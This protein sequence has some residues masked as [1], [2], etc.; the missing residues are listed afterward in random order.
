MDA[1]IA[2]ASKVDQPQLQPLSNF[3]SLKFRFWA[4]VS[5]VLLVYVH[6]Y[7]LDQTYLQPWT[8]PGHP[9]TVTA[10]FEYFFAN[11]ILRFRIP[12]LFVISGFLFAMQDHKPYK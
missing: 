11:G 6:G 12:M 5:M 2:T 1:S 8:I 9:M 4:F 3:T 7:N 10:Y